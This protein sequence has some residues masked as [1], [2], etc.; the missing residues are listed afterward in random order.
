M[1]NKKLENSLVDEIISQAFTDAAEEDFEEIE[2]ITLDAAWPEKNIKIERRAYDRIRRKG[3][4]ASAALKAVACLAIVIVVA[5]A[6]V[7]S[8]PTV[9]AGFLQLI[10]R[11]FSGYTNIEIAGKD[12]EDQI[13]LSDYIFEYIPNGFRLDENKTANNRNLS[14]VSDANGKSFTIKYYSSEKFLIQYD[15][16]HSIIENILIN[17]YSAYYC[18]NNYEENA[19]LSWSDDSCTFIIS[20]NISK[21]EMIKIASEIKK[22]VE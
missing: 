13:I 16:E 2:P 20:G 9:R 4:T 11:I 8:V 18:Y 12:Q 14:F 21:E 7:F 17:G 10:D 15:N 1:K 3:H 19:I 22:Y 6:F 5:A